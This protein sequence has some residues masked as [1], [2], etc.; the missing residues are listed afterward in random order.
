MARQTTMSVQIRAG[1]VRSSP[2]F[3]GTVLYAVA[4]GD[5]LVIHE[6]ADGWMK[7]S[8]TGETTRGWIHESALSARRIVVDPTG[9]D[10]ARAVESDEIALGGR[11]FNRQVEEAYRA[12]HPQIDFT[13]IDRMEKIEVNPEELDAFLREGQLNPPT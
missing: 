1:S 8:P 12:G 10:V 3:L 5:E 2:S 4:Y 11:G 7:V 6:Q 13:W 9:Q